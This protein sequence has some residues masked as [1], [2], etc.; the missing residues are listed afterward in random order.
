M[1]GF[2][3]A[4]IK[5]YLFGIYFLCIFVSL[6]HRF[7]KLKYLMKKCSNCD[8]FSKLHTKPLAGKCEWR[9]AITMEDEYCEAWTKK[10]DKLSELSTCVKCKAQFIPRLFKELTLCEKCEDELS[11]ELQQ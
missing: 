2:F 6:K 7:N 9:G 1:S 5:K 10:R 11:K 8:M 3:F 4:N